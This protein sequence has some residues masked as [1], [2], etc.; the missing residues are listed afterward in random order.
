MSVNVSVLAGKK[1]EADFAGF[2]QQ[3]SARGDDSG[4]LFAECKTYS[5][6][7]KK[8]FERMASLAK[9]FPGS[10]IV[11]CTLKD[12]LSD[13]EIKHI[14]RIA[15]AIAYAEDPKRTQA[16]KDD[17]G[18][19]DENLSSFEEVD[20]DAPLRKDITSRNSKPFWKSVWFWII[21]IIVIVAL[22]DL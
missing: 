15:K 6:F 2:W 10:V 7:E 14:T 21:A 1:L 17:F 18:L 9:T 19:N 4:I 16:L 8:D 3:V 5:D 20:A 22:L 13:F 11:F 12:K